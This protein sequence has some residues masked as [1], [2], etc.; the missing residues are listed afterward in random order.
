MSYAFV[1]ALDSNSQPLDSNSQDVSPPFSVCL[2]SEVEVPE[3][4]IG[5]KTKY[6]CQEAGIAQEFGR[7]VQKSQKYSTICCYVNTFW[8]VGCI[9]LCENVFPLM[10]C[11]EL[12]LGA[13]FNNAGLELT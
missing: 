1:L 5:R 9:G 2:I 13:T 3:N 8:N 11:L 10:K 6:G 12:G 7:C 4:Y